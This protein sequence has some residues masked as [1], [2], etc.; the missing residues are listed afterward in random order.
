MAS[1]PD[2]PLFPSAHRRG[3][4]KAAPGNGQAAAEGPDFTAEHEAAARGFFPVA[5]LDEAGRGP[6]AGPVVAAAVILDPDA[7][8]DGLDDSKKLSAAARERLFAEILASARAV[9]IAS[10]CAEGIDR[11]NILRA[12]LRAMRRAASSLAVR[13]RFALVDGRDVPLGLPCEARALVGGDGRS[14]SIAAASI[15][16]KVARDRMLTACGRHDARYGFESH[17]GYGSAGHRHALTLHGASARLHRMTF[18]PLKARGEPDL[19]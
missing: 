1:S 12:S 6:L 17:K 11:L 2:S 15:I 10:V 4:G 19:P 7:V 5:G 18:A 8:P 16:A 13:P 3:R 9:S 14:Q